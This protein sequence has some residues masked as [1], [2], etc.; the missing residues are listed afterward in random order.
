MVGD[1]TRGDPV[2]PDVGDPDQGGAGAHVQEGAG[3]PPADPSLQA[4]G[5]QSLGGGGNVPGE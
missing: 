3:V 2:G 1:V 5:G 4:A